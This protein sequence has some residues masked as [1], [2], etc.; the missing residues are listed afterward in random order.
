MNRSKFLTQYLPN[1][2]NFCKKIVPFIYFY[3]KQIDYFNQT[4]HGILTKEISLILPTFPKDRKEKRSI[5]SSLVTSFISLAYEGISGY[6]HN[7][8]KRHYKKHLWPWKIKL[9]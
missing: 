8:I 5:I 9:I 3:K 7:R 4:A 2:K 1:I 6:L